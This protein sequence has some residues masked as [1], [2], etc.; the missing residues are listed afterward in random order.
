[1]SQ[2]TLT[3]NIILSEIKLDKAQQSSLKSHPL[4]VTLYIDSMILNHTADLKRYIDD[5]YCLSV[6]LVFQLS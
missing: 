5:M 6:T 3:I 2:R 1:M 4:W